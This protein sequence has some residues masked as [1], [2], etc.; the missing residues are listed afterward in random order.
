MFSYC[1]LVYYSYAFECNSI[2]SV[3]FF[4]IKK[5]SD[6]SMQF[7]SFIMRHTLHVTCVICTYGASQEAF[8]HYIRVLYPFNA[9]LDHNYVFGLNVNTYADDTNLCVANSPNNKPQLFDQLGFPIIKTVWC[10]I[11]Q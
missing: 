5:S 2:F 11:F 6:F 9:Y 10:L 4:C 7:V 1:I 3:N 8:P